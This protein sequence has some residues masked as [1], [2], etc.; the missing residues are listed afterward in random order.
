M[1]IQSTISKIWNMN[2]E[3]QVKVIKQKSEEGEDE[4]GGGT[5]QE[6]AVN[7]EEP[8]SLPFVPPRDGRGLAQ[9]TQI[10]R[11]SRSRAFRG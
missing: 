7:I 9:A 8:L 1:D 4:N 11:G 10:R 5:S 6:E 2:S 3:E